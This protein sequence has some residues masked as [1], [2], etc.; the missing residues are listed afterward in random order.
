MEVFRRVL[1]DRDRRHAE[2]A[3]VHVHRTWVHRGRL[4][5]H[6]RQAA[7]ADHLE[8]HL[9][10]AAPWAHGLAWRTLVE[11]AVIVG[12]SHQPLE[13]VAVRSSLPAE[14]GRSLAW[15]LELPAVH[16][17]RDTLLDQEAQA[18]DRMTLVPVR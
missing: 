12:R 5:V 6:Q 15:L 16:T 3:E 13:V 10:M 11:P 14:A 1:E 9:H 17:V 2:A 8:F 7:A 4:H 18:R